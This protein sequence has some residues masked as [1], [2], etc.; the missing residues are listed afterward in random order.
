MSTERIR[1]NRLVDT[2]SLSTPRGEDPDPEFEEEKLDMNSQQEVL[3]P[4]FHYSY[5]LL[6]ALVSAFIVSNLG[7]AGVWIVVGHNS[8]AISEN[9]NGSSK[10]EQL[11]YSGDEKVIPERYSVAYFGKPNRA[12][13][14]LPLKEF[15]TAA[16]PCRY[17]D[18]TAWEWNHRRI[19][20]LFS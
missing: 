12:A 14:L 5:R 17:E 18:V 4:P 15:V 6:L 19:V 2:N 3:W 7:A 1:Y 9:H 10:L 20:K 13:S 16:T 8:G 11:L